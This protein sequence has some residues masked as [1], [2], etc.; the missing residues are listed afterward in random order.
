MKSIALA[1]LALAAF[2]LPAHAQPFPSRPIRIIVP[3][4]PGG[5]TDVAARILQKELLPVIGQPVVIENKPGAGSTI[6]TAEVAKQ[7]K[8]DGYTLVM[9][10][11]T[12]VITPH[13]YKEMPYDP[14]KDFTPV[15]KIAE[16]PYVLVVHPSLP[17]K[18]VAELIALAR[19]KPNSIDYAS[20]G[21][22][23]SQHLVGALFATMAG[24]PLNHV[25]YKGSSGAMNDLLGGQVKVSFV[26]VPNALPNLASG[27][28]RALAVT[29][30]RRYPGLPDVPTLDESGVK[31]Y[32][33]TLWLGLLAPPGT[34]RDIVLK[35]NTEITKV[36][37]GAEAKK[38]MSSAG[39]DVATRTP[40]EFG[41]LMQ[42][43]LDRWGKVVRATGAIVN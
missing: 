17:V 36:L 24:A 25:P 7:A 13:L 20:S 15:M 35:L 12:H 28:L 3:F 33:A 9:I 38:L 18:N 19:A 41:A 32:D 21:N 29:T 23:S 14:I 30:A 40:E 11:T 31:G 26:G 39:V 10:S 37:A 5:F 4:G 22:G 27:K 16:G 34:P 2:A 43:E 8:P 42:S 1:A 6:G